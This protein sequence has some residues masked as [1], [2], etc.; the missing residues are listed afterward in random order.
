MSETEE[1]VSISVNG[2]QYVPMS[3]YI[4]ITWDKVHSEIRANDQEEY[5]QQYRQWWLEEKEKRGEAE[6]ALKEAMRLNHAN[7]N[8]QNQEIASLNQQL[9]DANDYKLACQCD[10]YD[11][12]YKQ[13]YEELQELM[14]NR[15]TATNYLLTSAIAQ[16]G[17]AKMHVS[18]LI[19]R[20][21]KKE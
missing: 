12:Q 1:Q 19:E 20:V 16:A 5:A 15:L 6:D 18:E 2:E 10:M 8:Y 21:S 3:D 13:A 7:F 4:K 17:N 9:K 14:N 11:S